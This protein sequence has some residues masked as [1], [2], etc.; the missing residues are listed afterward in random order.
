MIIF[1]QGRGTGKSTRLLILS[2]YTGTPIV[3]TSRARQAHLENEKQKLNC[4]NAKI[5]LLEDLKGT[6]TERVF[7]DE[8]Y[9]LLSYLMKRCVGA[10]VAAVTDTIPFHE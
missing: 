6:N 1:N 10:E 9:A 7:V 5:I 8:G 3:V 2:D 4:N